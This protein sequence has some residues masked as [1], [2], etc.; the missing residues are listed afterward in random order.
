MQNRFVLLRFDQRQLNIR[1]LSTIIIC[2][3]HLD[4]QRQN[5]HPNSNATW[6]LPTLSIGSFH[7]ASRRMHEAVMAEFGDPPAT[8]ENEISL[9]EF[10][11]RTEGT[12]TTTGA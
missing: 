8:V 10:P 4:L 12:S 3:F 11:S 6:S 9:D 5:A 2:R 7:A 1:S